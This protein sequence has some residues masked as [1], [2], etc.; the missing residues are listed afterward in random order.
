MFAYE[1]FLEPTCLVDEVK[2]ETLCKFR[3]NEICMNIMKRGDRS[4]H[5]KIYDLIYEIVRCEVEEDLNY[6][7]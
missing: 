1:P 4:D 3:I 2:I 7:N 6:N 5:S